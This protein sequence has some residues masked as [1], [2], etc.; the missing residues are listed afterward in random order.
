[1]GAYTVLVGILAIV[2]KAIVDFGLLALLLILFGAGAA[3]ISA[4]VCTLFRRTAEGKIIAKR[5]MLVGLMPLLV[6]AAS[7]VIKVM[8]DRRPK[9]SRPAADQPNP[10][11]PPKPTGRPLDATP[12][13]NTVEQRVRNVLIAELGRQKFTSARVTTLSPLGGATVPFNDPDD[14]LFD[15][16]GVVEFIMELEVEF[17]RELA[18]E[19]PEAD[20]EKLR[21]VGD[22]IEY[23]EFKIRTGP[24]AGAGKPTAFEET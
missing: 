20:A 7:V 17:K 10:L 2:L 1:M 13:A 16:L 21:T 8:P 6:V 18:A 22:V 3:L 14:A 23:I 11:A 5:L 19:I 15:E 12:G 24:K 9:L 4:G